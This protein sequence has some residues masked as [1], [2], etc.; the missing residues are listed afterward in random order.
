MTIVRYTLPSSLSSFRRRQTKI[1]R[2]VVAIDKLPANLRVPSIQRYHLDMK[3]EEIA[4]LTA[5]P[6][7]DEPREPKCRPTRS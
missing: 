3:Q 7:G 5:P 2:K 6:V 4:G 1:E